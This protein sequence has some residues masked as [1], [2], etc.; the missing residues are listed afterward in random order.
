VQLLREPDLE[1][2][3]QSEDLVRSPVRPRACDRSHCACVSPSLPLSQRNILNP[4]LTTENQDKALAFLV[5]VEAYASITSPATRKTRAPM[6]FSKY[7]EVIGR[8]RW[9]GCF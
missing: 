6:L 8:L 7:I 2:W 9:V 4:F 1:S 5:A 3:M